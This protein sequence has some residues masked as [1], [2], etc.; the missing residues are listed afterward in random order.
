MRLGFFFKYYC[1]STTSQLKRIRKKVYIFYVFSYALCTLSG[2]ILDIIHKHF[3]QLI[4][5]IFFADKVKVKLMGATSGSGTANHS[6][7]P[8]FTPGF[9]VGFVLLDC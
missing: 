5:K 6:G 8:E 7:A 1:V 9:L 4:S 3:F 2:I